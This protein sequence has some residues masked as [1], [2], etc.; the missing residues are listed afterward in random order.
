MGGKR[1]ARPPPRR[2]GWERSGASLRSSPQ[3][4]HHSALQWIVASQS[5]RP[6]RG[7][8]A[9]VQPPPTVQPAAPRPGIGGSLPRRDGYFLEELRPSDPR[10]QLRGAAPPWLTL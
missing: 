3:P 5:S 10:E 7:L 9:S 1:R 8:V 6:A 4:Q 2:G